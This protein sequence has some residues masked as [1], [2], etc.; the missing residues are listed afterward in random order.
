MK[1]LKITY[2]ISTGLVSI[3]MIYAA[4]AYLTEPAMEKAFGHLG[5]P[6]YFRIELAI[7]KLVGVAL[8]LNPV[9]GWLKEWTYAGFVIVFISAFVAHIASG[10]AV[11]VWM[12]PLFFLAI[13]IVSYAS[14]RG[15]LRMKE[16]RLHVPPADI[17]CTIC[18]L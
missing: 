13:H 2:W 10:D 4:I 11:M 12:M 7:G 15:L 8:L 14:Y 16:N 1:A 5:F 18:I 9:C 6:S 3:F 17:P